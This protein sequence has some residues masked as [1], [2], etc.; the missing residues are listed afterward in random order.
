MTLRYRALKDSEIR[1]ITLI[2]D[3]SDPLYRNDMICCK[4]EHFCLSENQK[5][6]VF[7]I[8]G[9]VK[10]WTRSWD[11]N[12]VD[13]KQMEHSLLRK[14]PKDKTQSNWMSNALKIPPTSSGST[15]PTS[16]F[17]ENTE[18][19]LPWRYI[20]GDYVALSY[21]W[22]PQDSA[23]DVT[24]LVDNEKFKVRS[25]LAAA[26]RQLKVCP[27]I[28]QGFKLWIDM[29]CINQENTQEREIQVRKMKEIYASAWHVVV[30]LGVEAEGSDLAM[31]ALRYLSRRHQHA[32][33]STHP[34]IICQPGWR[35]ATR[36][37]Y[38]SFKRDIHVHLYR[39]L[40]RQYWYRLWILQEIALGRND[41]PVLCGNSYI[42]WSDIVAATTLIQQNEL[43]FWMATDWALFFNKNGLTEGEYGY[44]KWQKADI[45]RGSVRNRDQW[46]R[47]EWRKFADMANLQEDQSRFIL[48]HPLEHAKNNEIPRSNPQDEGMPVGLDT[49][50]SQDQRF[51]KALLLGRSAAATNPCDKIYGL[52]EEVFITFAR[53]VITKSHSLSL[54]RFTSNPVGEILRPGDS[55]T[56]RKR[57]V[58]KYTIS[59]ACVHT[60]LPSWAPCWICDS[61]ASWETKGYR[62]GIFLPFNPNFETV[63]AISGKRC[64]LSLSGASFD[65]V[66]NLSAFHAC[67]VDE[68][69]PYNNSSPPTE[70]LSKESTAKDRKIESPYSSI[71]EALWRT[72]VGNRSSSGCLPAPNAYSCILSIRALEAWQDDFLAS[73]KAYWLGKTLTQFR[74][75]NKELDIFGTKLGD[76][77]KSPSLVSN[78]KNGAKEWADAASCARTTLEYRR[79]ATTNKGYLGVVPAGARSGDVVAVLA[80]TEMPVILRPADEHLQNDLYKIVGVAYVH[81]LMD[82]E[83]MGMVQ[84]G[85][86]KVRDLRLC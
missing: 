13:L 17:D 74:S 42:N 85:K 1:L 37:R 26:M 36:M 44:I 86:V 27:R 5:S 33:S 55:Q 57:H 43:G 19:T 2:T 20:W 32:S 58:E 8:G 45:T 3:P 35:V 16:P 11:R 28:K 10:G 82:G 54:L 65:R 47:P 76:I 39:L 79:L 15:P 64:I 21:L 23:T 69:F 7:K 48:S 71:S 41:M 25:N 72:L 34:D 80:G 29:I 68:M 30:W 12:G 14:S 61:G 6:D 67:E 22:G 63:V 50:H 38:T 53:S 73:D 66:E 84:T 9:K 46:C 75:R 56:L 83:M 40:T 24:I 18:N 81:G 52:L 4:L 51:W 78:F 62:A 59:S 60:D 77:L 49:T 70:T 31:M